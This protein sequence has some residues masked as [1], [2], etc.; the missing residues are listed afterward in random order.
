MIY[1][2]LFVC[3]TVRTQSP[4][5]HADDLPEQRTI[6]AIFMN[7]VEPSRVTAKNGGVDKI[8]RVAY[9]PTA[10]EILWQIPFLAKDPIRVAEDA[11]RFWDDNTV[12]R[13][14]VS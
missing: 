11:N 8:D 6:R 13:P 14:T 1:R 10:P 3:I 5:G 9:V 2:P 7:Y 12:T 4:S